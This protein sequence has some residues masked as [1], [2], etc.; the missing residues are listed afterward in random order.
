MCFKFVPV[1][2]LGFG[3][4][5]DDDDDGIL[6]RENILGGALGLWLVSPR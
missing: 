4:V 3:L 1:S 2:G 5:G 6:K